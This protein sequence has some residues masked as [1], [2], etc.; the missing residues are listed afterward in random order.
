MKKGD[1]IKIE[2]VGRLESGEIFDLTKEDLAKENNIH[3]PN[4]KYKPVTVIIGAGFV[5]PGLDKA[6]TEMMVGDK[7][8]VVVKPDEAFGIRNPELVR[9]IPEKAFE[10]KHIVPGMV[11]DFGN[12]RGRIQSMSAGRVRV[13][14]NHPLAGKT[15]KY[16]V[17]I[18]ECIEDQ[19]QQ[20]ESILDF[21]GIEPKIYMV[22][23]AYE[24][25]ADPS[26]QAKQKISSLILE[27][28][29]GV[30][31]VRFVQSFDR[32][33]SETKNDADKEGSKDDKKEE[34][35]KESRPHRPSK[36]K[37]VE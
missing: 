21:F 5:V 32:N 8:E 1:F 23:G 24:I 36:K 7:K 12:T 16:D 15:L 35:A 4:I 18:R 20:V 17:E 11:V 37:G 22:P 27:Y 34:S 6:L 9:T 14:F 31:R 13:D 2:F 33:K 28:V 26:P 3:N 25:E 10:G 19:I 29:N 30:N